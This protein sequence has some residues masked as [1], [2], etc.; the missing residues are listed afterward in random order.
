MK[1]RTLLAGL[2]LLT[3]AFGIQIVGSA[4]FPSASLSSAS[5][6][7]LLPGVAPTLNLQGSFGNNGF[8][9]AVTNYDSSNT[10]SFS[11]TQ[12]T[13]STTI[14]TPTGGQSTLF[15]NVQN[16]PI[17]DSATL[18]VTAS[19]SG[20]TSESTSIVGYAKKSALVPIF[21]TPEP[22]FDGFTVAVTN[23]Q[24]GFTWTFTNDLGV[25]ATIDSSGLITVTRLNVPDPTTLFVVTSRTGYLSGQTSVVG[26]NKPLTES[27]TPTL[28]AF[29][30]GADGLTVPLTN[31]DPAFNW[32]IGTTGGGA[33][34]IDPNGLITVTD[35]IYGQPV[36][37][38]VT[39]SRYGYTTKSIT[40]EAQPLM[41]PYVPSFG[42]V[43]STS[44]GF[45]TELT[46]FDETFIYQVSVSVGSAT[47]NGRYI[48]VTGLEPGQSST[49]TV[50]KIREDSVP[51][52]AR[53]TGNAT[54][55][56]YTPLLGNTQRQED[57][58]AIPF[59][60]YDPDFDWNITIL[61]NPSPGVSAMFTYTWF[62]GVGFTNLLN[63]V[64]AAHGETVDLVVTASRPGYVSTTLQLTGTAISCLLYTSPSPRD[65]AASRMPSSA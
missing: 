15:V 47:L 6:E 41:P 43:V 54:L 27:P 35:L 40:F 22:T 51:A 16:I 57:G 60:N 65:Y 53:I 36:T 12:G 3:G 58:Y 4:L 50:L 14:R 38:Q 5:A 11:V 62:P 17:D 9:V 13:V 24:P 63:V 59:L 26:Q 44:D 61:G 42:E 8:T 20:Y 33:A 39:L 49:L 29:E 64:G 19:K 34:A 55:G 21:G 45:T 7:D 23:Y 32:A 28:G 48:T 30:L 1:I 10:Y 46:D 37:V 31:Y 56:T 2:A 18:T 52:V 25:Y